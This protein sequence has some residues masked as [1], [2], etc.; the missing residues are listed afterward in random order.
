MSM[1][2]DV[3]AKNITSTGAAG[4]GGARTRVKGV[5]YVPGTTAGSVSFKDG[6]ASGTELI[7][8]DTPGLTAG[9]GGAINMLFPAEGV[10]FQADPYLTLTNVTSV[11]FFY[12]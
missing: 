4:I 3:K 5:Y 10:L 2:T 12:G 1:Q 6:G 8:I 9:N 11:T 7:K